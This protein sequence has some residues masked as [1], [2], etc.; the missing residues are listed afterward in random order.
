MNL[1][2]EVRVAVIV[3]VSAWAVFALLVATLGNVLVPEPG[4]SLAVPAALALAAATAP[5]GLALGAWFARRSSGARVEAGLLLATATVVSGL[6]LDALLFLS[7]GFRHPGVEAARTPTLAATLLL[8]YAAQGA[9]LRPSR[10]RGAGSRARQRTETALERAVSLLARAT[11]SAPS[12][13]A[14][15]SPRSGSRAASP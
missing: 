15:R 3:G 13:S 9:A 2:A 4:E 1:A 7:N 8:G 12:A 10:G 6:T 5:A 14:S 11:A